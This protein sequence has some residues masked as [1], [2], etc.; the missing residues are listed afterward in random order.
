[1]SALPYSKKEAKAWAQETV[2]GFYECSDHADQ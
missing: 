1:M 2:R